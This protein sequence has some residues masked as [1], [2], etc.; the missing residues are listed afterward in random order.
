MDTECHICHK[1][2][3]HQLEKCSVC[4][5]STCEHCLAYREDVEALFWARYEYLH[6]GPMCPPCETECSSRANREYCRACFESQV[7]AVDCD[8]TDA[9]RTLSHLF[10]QY[11][12][13]RYRYTRDG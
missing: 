13:E 2:Y 4:G 9:D 5:E 8:F 11:K 10:N 6:V 7:W 1:A 12:F 3:A